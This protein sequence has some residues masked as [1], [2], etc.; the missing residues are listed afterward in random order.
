M[1]RAEITGRNQPLRVVSAEKY[2]PPLEGVL[3][4]TRYAGLCHTDLHFLMADDVMKRRVD[5][6]GMD[7]GLTAIIQRSAILSI[8]QILS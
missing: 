7:I 4:K 8:V 5:I 1:R 6:L 2:V 3:V